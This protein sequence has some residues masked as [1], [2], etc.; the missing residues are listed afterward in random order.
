MQVKTIFKIPQY[1]TYMNNVN[2]ALQLRYE[3]DNK[4]L[5]NVKKNITNVDR[6]FFLHKQTVKH[7]V[8]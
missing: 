7:F 6:R 8:S 2:K 1:F 3:P 5:F 4:K